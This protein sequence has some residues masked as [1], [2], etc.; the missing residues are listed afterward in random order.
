LKKSSAEPKNPLLISSLLHAFVVGTIFCLMS[1]HFGESEKVNIEVFEQP[2]V[3]PQQMQLN[4]PRDQIKPVPIA[5][6]VFGLSRK[7][8]TD[9]SSGVSEKAGNT[10]AI[11]QDDKKLEASDQDLPIPTDEYLV[12]SMPIL[13]DEVRVIYPKEAK[14][15]N[16]EGPVVMDILI[17]AMG[18]VRDLKVLSGP[19][20]GLN[21]AASLAIMQFHFIPA[22]VKT[23]PVAARIRYTYRFVLEK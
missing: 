9:E 2:V 1:F 21:E 11:A 15:K 12:D 5:R 18:V 17:D 10:L 16:I 14:F 20:F 6:K 3:A 23:G 19:G 8:V 4:Q 7:A 13:K 22:K